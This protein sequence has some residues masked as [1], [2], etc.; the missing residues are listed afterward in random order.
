MSVTAK[1]I[2]EDIARAKSYIARKDYLRT[3]EFLARAVKGVAASQVFGREKF[4]VQALLEEVFRDFNELS[5]IQRLF[6]KG[7]NYQRGKE[8]ALYKT[9]IRLAAKLKAAME[10][11]KIA[12]QRER[13]AE[14]DNM[15]LEAQKHLENQEHLEARKLFR[16]A[17]DSYSDIPG[18][19]SDIGTRLMMGGLFQEAAE[20]LKRA[21]EQ[22]GSDNR[23][24]SSL[25]MC[26]E[27]LGE[28]GKAID[29]VKD[30]MRRLGINESLEIKLAKLH[31]SRREWGEAH[32]Y[33]SSVTQK[34]PLNV[35]AEKIVKKTEP[36]I[37]GRSGGAPK[38][39][40]GS[41]GSGGGKAIKLDI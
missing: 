30:A 17:S 20:Y 33:A 11:A 39:G 23:A 3:L 16:K 22:N 15:L 36:K 5:M 14:L 27:G 10:K 38:A 31:L 21:I 26:Y 35:E 41:G 1:S 12:K 7:L 4:E 6:P 19:N 28:A 34:N 24:H 18:I 37:Y 29:A 25:I 8:A 13:F 9:L 40:G 32:K 2:R